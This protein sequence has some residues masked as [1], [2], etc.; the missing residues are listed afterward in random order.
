MKRRA[1]WA[2]LAAAGAALLLWLGAGD[3]A[4]PVQAAALPVPAAA[5]AA[6]R[7]L[8]AAS[9]PLAVGAPLSAL[10][11]AQRQ[12][13]RAAWQDRLERAQAAL[14]A[15]ERH[16]RYPH[17]SRPA[18]EHPDQLRPFDPIAED[19]ALVMPGGAATRGV[20]LKTTQERVFLAG[21]ESARITITLVDADDRPLPLRITRAVLHEATP[22]G[23]TATTAEAVL[24]FSDNAGTLSTTVQPAAQG[25]GGFAGLVRLDVWMEHAGQP[26][27]IYFD[28]IY[29]PEQAARWL[30]GVRES[31]VDGS[32]EFALQAEVR[33]AGRYVVSARVDDANGQPVAVALFNDDLAAGTREFRLPVFGRLI[34]DRDPA[35]PLRV[36]DVE[37]FLLKPDA[38]PDRVMLP[39]LAGVV[40][41]SRRYA[42]AQFSEALWSS[43]ERT[44]YLAELGRDVADAQRELARLGP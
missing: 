29:S 4:P 32:L 15:Y 28:L 25:F 9:A 35:F 24:A 36:R 37:A 38:Y 42:P 41:E 1:A 10:G 39:R 31:L 26:G 2:A 14:A 16:A 17:G 40:H 19:R 12:A 30:P 7:A 22:P 43:D 23:R 33:I 27:T 21:D 11:Q 34:R 13:Q 5:P 44:R 18:D 8:P 6:G 20:R 3:P